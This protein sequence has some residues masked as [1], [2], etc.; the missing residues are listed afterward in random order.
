MFPNRGTANLL[1]PSVTKPS[2]HDMCSRSRIRSDACLS[3]NTA[4]KHISSI[5]RA[6]QMAVFKDSLIC[7]N[8]ALVIPSE[9]CG[10]IVAW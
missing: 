3:T 7:Y 6:Y 8:K 5:P 1:S 9:L 4:I 10:E 2:C